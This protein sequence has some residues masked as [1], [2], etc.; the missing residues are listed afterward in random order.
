[1]T[2]QTKSMTNQ[3]NPNKDFSEAYNLDEERFE[4][5]FESDDATKNATDF[6]Q[7]LASDVIPSM[8]VPKEAPLADRSPEQRAALEAIQSEFPTP[9]SKPAPEPDSV[10]EAPSSKP[11]IAD[12]IVD[13]VVKSSP[14]NIPRAARIPK[15]PP[16]TDTSTIENPTSSPSFDQKKAP[17]SQWTSPIRSFFAPLLTLFKP[18]SESKESSRVSSLSS[19]DALTRLKKREAKLKDLLDKKKGD[20][21]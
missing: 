3:K 11:P 9:V 16:Q 21:T 15:S 6:L 12:P 18:K 8:D 19:E 17:V 13:H 2:F 4:Q 14:K 20:L 10:P 5:L 1:M 7:S